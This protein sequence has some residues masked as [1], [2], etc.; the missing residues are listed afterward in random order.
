MLN[1]DVSLTHVLVSLESSLYLEYDADMK[2]QD[3]LQSAIARIE[4]KFNITI[5]RD[6]FLIQDENALA[7]EEVNLFL[8][9]IVASL[10]QLSFYIMLKVFHQDVGIYLSDVNYLGYDKDRINTALRYLQS[11]DTYAQMGK[12]IIPPLYGALDNIP[13]CAVKRLFTIMLMYDKLGIQEGV[14]VVASFLRLGGIL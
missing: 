1:K 5:D 2:V 4:N 13:M 14:S 3:I 12:K 9:D 8:R 11:V 7:G 6:I 10:Q